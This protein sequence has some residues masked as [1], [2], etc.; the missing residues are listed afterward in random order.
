[1]DWD[2]V[3]MKGLN[4][5]I[6]SEYRANGKVVS[7]GS[8]SVLLLHHT[9][10]RTGVKRVSP[11]TYQV[12]GDRFVVFGSKSGT[13]T[14]P[15]WYHNIVANPRVTIEV[16]GSTFEATA[17]VAE[18]DERERLWTKQKLDHP[19]YAEYEQKTDRQI[20]VVV[21]ER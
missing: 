13:S 16:D 17:R 18:G 14:H 6:I 5:R 15:H 9:G 21:L 10:A 19:I 8:M 11:L 4:E 2:P 3:F 1:M 12:D 20:P 7:A